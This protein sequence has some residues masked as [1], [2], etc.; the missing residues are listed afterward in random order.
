MT[1]LFTLFFTLLAAQWSLVR[2]ASTARGL[3]STHPSLNT[4]QGAGGPR[5]APAYMVDNQHNYYKTAPDKGR[6]NGPVWTY[7]G[8]LDNYL[9]NLQSGFVVRGG[10]ARSNG[11]RR[12]KLKSNS[13]AQKRQSSDF[14]LSSLGPLGTQPHAGGGDYQFFRNVVEDFGA[15]NSG[16][17]DATEALNAA[18]ASWNKDSVGGSQTRCGEKCG[19][20]F[21][22]G[23]IVYFPGGTYKVCTPVIQYYYTQFVGDPNDMPIIKGCDD[24]Q[25]IALFDVDPYIPGASGSQWYIN[26]N[27]FFRQI[28]N[29]RFDLTEMPESTA[30]NDQDL[31]PTGIHWQ[32]SQATSLQNLVFDMPTTSTTTAV[33]IFTENGSGGFVSDLEFN[34]GNIGWRAGSQQYTA[35]NLV[36][37]QCNTAVQMVWDWGWA[38][39]QITVNGGSIAFNISGVGGDSG[40]GTGSV[41]I[42]DSTISDVETGV[43]TNSL[44][45]SPNIVLD[46][47]NFKNVAKP[48]AVEGGSTILS[49]NSDLWATGKRYNGSDG[50]VQT[51]AVTAPGRGK[52][53]E[54]SNGLLYVRSRP[55]YEKTGVGSFLVATTD[56]GCKND[57]TGD[58]ASCVNAFLR[59]AR[60]GG[61]IAYF[62]A[63]VYAVGSTVNIPTGSVVQGSLWS[64]IVGSGFYFSDMKNPKVMVQVGNKGDI[65]TM[66]ITEMMFSV[67]GATAG[68]IL[69]EWNV[70]AKSQGAAAM[71][72]SHFRVGGAIGTDL[73]LSKCPKFSNNA[74]C[75]AASLMFRITPQS[76]GYFEN[77]WAWVA[78]HD[79]DKSIYNQP[80]SSSTQ[81]S[82]FGA[83]G[84]LIE[85][86]GPSWFYG[87]GSEHSVLYNYLISGA[88]SVYMGHIQT[89]SP[90]YQ[91]NPGPPAPFRAVSGASSSFP[92]DPDFSE[93]EVEANVWDDRCNYAWG[94]QII[95]SKDVMI[96]AAGL[97]SFFNEYYQDCIPTHNCQDRI[98]E[99]KGSTGVVIYN[100]FT[101]ATIDIASGIDDTSVPQ[102][103]NQRGFTTEVSVWIPLPGSD[104][105]D[106]VW[107]GTDIWAS[108]TVSC[109]SQSRSCMLVIPT[110]SLGATTTIQPKS[111][112]TS[113]EY[114]GYSSTTIGGVATTVFVTTTTTLTISVPAITT[115]GI[116]FSNVNVTK[117]GATPIT[118]YP[119]LSVPPVIVTLP[120]GEGGSTTR[121]IPLP[122]WPQIEGGPLVTYTDPATLPPNSGSGLPTS[123]TYYTPISSTITVPGATVTT[124]TFPGSTGVIT[125]ECPATTSIVFATPPVAVGTTCTGSSDLTLNFACPPTRVLTFL[126]PAT[127]V[128]TVDCS[129]VTAWTTGSTS[130]TTPLPVYTTWPPYASIIPEE[131]EIEDPEPDDDGVHVPCTAWFFFFCISWD[132][133]R[134]RS[135]YWILPPGIYGPGPPPINI[136]HP[137][138]G[139]TI[140]G[141]LPPW[142]RITIGP[143]H[144]LTTES[145]PEC[146]TETAE[147][148]TTTNYVSAGTTTSST[149]LCETITGCSISVSDSSTVVIGSQTAAPIGHFGDERWATMT[150]G[151]AY[152]NS[153]Y[154]A[155][156]SALAR[157][158][159]SAG[160]TTL[161]FT[162]GPTAGPTCRGASTACGGTVCSG[163]WCNPTPTGP[164]P[165]YQD[166]KDPS[167]GGYS[168]PTTSIGPSTTTTPPTSAPTPVTPQTR[169]PIN[170][171]NEADFPGHADIQ[172]GDQ[173]DYSTAFSDLRTQMGDND[174]I[175]PGDPAVT[176]RRTDSHGVNYDYSCSWVPGCK[177]EVDKQSFGFPLGSPSLITAYLL[178]RED[179][180]KYKIALPTGGPSQQQQSN[181]VP[182][183]IALP[184]GG[185]DPT[186]PDPPP[187]QE[188]QPQQNTWA[189]PSANPPGLQ[190]HNDTY[191][192]KYQYSNQ[193]PQ[194]GYQP[195][196]PQEVGAFT[197]VV[198]NWGPYGYQPAVPGQ[199][200]Y[201]QPQE[202]VLPPAP[203]AKF[204]NHTVQ[205]NANN[206]PYFAPLPTQQQQ[207]QQQQQPQQ[208]QSQP[209]SAGPKRYYK[210][211]NTCRRIRRRCSGTR[212]CKACVAA[213][214]DCEYDLIG[215]D[216]PSNPKSRK[217]NLDAVA[218]GSVGVDDNGEGSSS[219]SP[220]NAKRQKSVRFA[221]Q[222]L[223]RVRPRYAVPENGNCEHCDAGGHEG[224]PCDANHAEQIEC[225]QCTKYRN[226]VDAN[227]VC[228]AA[229]G[230]Y[231][232]KRFA[233]SRPA[234]PMS[235]T[236]AS[237]CVG[238]KAKRGNH[239]SAVCDVDVQLKIGCSTCSREGRLCEAYVE[240]RANGQVTG[241]PE[242]WE[243][244]WDR[245][246]PGDGSLVQGR[247]PWWR[248]MCQGCIGDVGTRR[249]NPCS[250]I[251]DVRLDGYKCL[252]CVEQNRPCVEAFT[253][254][255]FVNGYVWDGQ[256]DCLIVNGRPVARNGAAKCENCKVNRTSCRGFDGPDE[257]ACSKCTAWGLTCVVQRDG[258]PVHLPHPDRKAIGWTR[259][260]G[261]TGH[262]FVACVP[263]RMNKRNCDRKRPCD[264]CVKFGSDCDAF[265]DGG[266]KMKRD[267]RVSGADSADYY[268]ALGYGPNGVDS[269][270]WNTPVHELIGPNHPRWVRTEAQP[271]PRQVAAYE[272]A[273]A[274]VVQHPAQD[275][276]DREFGGV[277]PDEEE[278]EE[279]EVVPE[280]LRRNPRRSTREKKPSEKGKAIPP[281]RPAPKPAPKPPYTGP[282]RGRGRPRKNPPPAPVE[283]VGEGYDNFW[284]AN[285]Y[286]GVEDN[287]V[288]D[289][290]GIGLESTWSD[291]D[292]SLL[293]NPQHIGQPPQQQYFGDNL[294]A[295]NATENGQDFEN[296][297]TNFNDYNAY[298]QPL[299][300]QVPAPFEGPPDL[301][302]IQRFLG[303]DAVMSDSDAEKLANEVLDPQFFQIADDVAQEAEKEEQNGVLAQL[304]MA[305]LSFS[306]DQRFVPVELRNLR[307]PE[308]S[309]PPA[310][311]QVPAPER[312]LLQLSDAAGALP[313]Q[314]PF[315]PDPA[316]SAYIQNIR[317]LLKKW[318]RPGWNILSSIPDLPLAEGNPQ[319][320]ADNDGRTCEEYQAEPITGDLCRND[321]GPGDACESLEHATARPAPFMVCDP[322]DGRSKM[323]LF[324]GTQPLTRGEFLRMR[325]YACAECARREIESG[326]PAFGMPGRPTHPVTGCACATKVVGRR[327]C[328]HHRY[329]LAKELMVQ[330]MF[331]SEWAITNFG[332][333]TCLFC[334]VMPARTDTRGDV[335]GS[336]V[337]LCLNCQGVVA[338]SN[339]P[340]VAAGVEV[341]LGGTVP[342]SLKE[343]VWMGMATPP[344]GDI[345]GDMSDLT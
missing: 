101:V 162:P 183:Q 154:A 124:V 5:P 23:A 160:G 81:I 190:P 4:T 252:N 52:G 62:P 116:P 174:L 43:L 270:R 110:S 245:P 173:D 334:K 211:C 281:A 129:L 326:A 8:S 307:I 127:A 48:V 209:G 46:N 171:F 278:E 228:R 1:V 267:Y 226:L 275:L 229:G 237:C 315:S 21:S 207:Q 105:V 26:Q 292:I 13:T 308:V 32:V 82:I 242:P 203:G 289:D 70:A 115:D 148:C 80:D 331:V 192:A 120:N 262:L 219:S 293:N 200:P 65:G 224:R 239:R 268:M 3:N 263:C 158:D 342:E 139:V 230:E 22:Q 244:M 176:L 321:V 153:V 330:T 44:S 58:Q 75:I 99:V 259:N 291:N 287:R 217:R 89:E 11:T 306:A 260:T 318:K 37:N 144:R 69:M 168:A 68:A 202:T 130:T 25:G 343:Q 33:G 225:S 63:G 96:H 198:Q 10:Y 329:R 56:G 323:G 250:W 17:T 71:W 84:M 178:V 122:P 282:K 271:T 95:D 286:G 55:Q 297:L 294:A 313:P 199:Q 223:T 295:A 98:L 51:G 59:K 210:T 142:P 232:Q 85:S 7:S 251:N 35:R 272:Q 135:W 14:W 186:Q 319:Y 92:N 149:T 36:F 322:C 256:G 338:E 137:P 79:N 91:P 316:E 196:P 213:D 303:Q 216:K 117:S 332:H 325:A 128:A 274:Q 112:T 141:N 163:Y 345:F 288:G 180:T 166:P 221:E 283:G 29:F 78:D 184:S 15:D 220:P 238:C 132:N 258:Q 77:V 233:N 253:G 106:I 109:P 138:P 215:T 206:E 93:C 61:Q 208:Q 218:S 246:R 249:L 227:H 113:L 235:D 340:H 337:Y 279:E 41:S 147:A 336:L 236:E 123:T 241:P 310:S 285:G 6:Q 20:T 60:D 18:S 131:E 39:Q 255:E 134:V 45:T 172:S 284:Q 305:V 146:E 143:D 121:T 125:I 119:S 276:P 201:V 104:S 136:I 182:D 266:A 28:R 222:P 240:R 175:G 161:S 133:V 102:D 300:D 72:D 86:E 320:T 311:A 108:P 179:Y 47:T 66:E 212:P 188:P 335:F 290:S 309:D 248:R 34:G 152:T 30:E 254:Q 53:L 40:Q 231:W 312:F 167:S 195:N 87:G 280:G 165:G 327:L 74:E 27:Q 277:E 328:V 97:Y 100:L 317:T 38:W 304:R 234:Y 187:Q 170:C 49:G 19:N 302:E 204:I 299:Q 273:E 159:A 2:S 269:N 257:F 177:T 107:V 50:S 114:G 296:W 9:T 301:S 341:W 164:P 103:G 83:R 205:T 64:Q 339:E 197:Q 57:A 247:R 67:R 73:D 94:L 155:I 261:D 169:G 344:G 16:E 111:F 118:I 156:E 298:D 151:D 126:G 54:D 324:Q 12:M 214:V 185:R 314:L 24:F 145:E 264:S 157:D 76:N 191:N 90:Y 88:K 181:R 243:R 189:P 265:L 333:R 140:R 150:L 42:I 31:V 193:P 194:N